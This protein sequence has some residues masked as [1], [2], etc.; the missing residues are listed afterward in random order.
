MSALEHLLTLVDAYRGATGLSVATVSKRFLGRSTR[1]EEIRRGGDVGARNIER[2]LRKMSDEWPAQ[3]PWPPVVPRPNG[4]AR[5]S[6][7]RAA[8][9]E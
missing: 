9:D 1:I 4:G 6:P 3:A 2:V 5:L 7:E 8:E